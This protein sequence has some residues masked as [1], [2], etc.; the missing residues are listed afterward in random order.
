MRAFVTAGAG[1]LAAVLWFD[2][3]HDM[4]VVGHRR[5]E[6]PQ[7]VLESIAGYYRRVTT[8]ARPMNRLVAVAM[9][10]TIAAIGLQIAAGTGPEWVAVT[11]L[12]L[13]VLAVGLAGSRTV[14]SAVRLGERRDSSEVQSSLARGIWRDHL[15][16]LAGIALVLVFEL[17]FAN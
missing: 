14:R 1:F 15:I 16:C 13:T 5:P 3:M 6:L 11:T 17:A 9:L 8:E 2:L 4:Q 12:V 7:S 10:G